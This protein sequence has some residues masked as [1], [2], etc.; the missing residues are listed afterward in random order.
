MLT[1]DQLKTKYQAVID[2]VPQLGASLKNVHFENEK[3]LI[4]AAA[5]NEEIKNEIWNAIKR[6]DPTYSDLTA[7]I[8]VD[9]SLPVPT[10]TYT[11]QSGDTLSKI[12]RQFYGNPNDY[13]KIFQANTDQLKDPNMI[14]VGQVLKIPR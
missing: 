8:T 5:P 11:V 1:L 4:R 2:L 9:T 14:N 6:V 12:A 7:D 13:M 10:R 3:L